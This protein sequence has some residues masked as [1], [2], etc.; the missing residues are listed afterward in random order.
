MARDCVLIGRKAK[1][2]LWYRT[3][4]TVEEGLAALK[5]ETRP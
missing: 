1:D 3:R 2:E 4:V 5:D